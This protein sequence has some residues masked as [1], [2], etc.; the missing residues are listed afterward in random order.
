MN[1]TYLLIKAVE[2]QEPPNW[3]CQESPKVAPYVHIQSEACQLVI[4]IIVDV[5]GRGS[6]EIIPVSFDSPN[7]AYQAKLPFV[8]LRE[9]EVIEGAREKSNKRVRKIKIIQKEESR[10]K[11]MKE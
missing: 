4:P 6:D 2:S 11:D 9:Y 3:S 1:R 10:M 8:F 7:I 5:I